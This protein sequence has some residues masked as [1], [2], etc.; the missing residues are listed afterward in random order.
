MVS[1]ADPAVAWDVA[2][3]RALSAVSFTSSQISIL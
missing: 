2:S 1:D 3:I